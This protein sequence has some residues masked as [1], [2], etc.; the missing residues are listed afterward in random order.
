MQHIRLFE[1]RELRIE[2]S[3]YHGKRYID[4][5]QWFYDPRTDKWYA[6]RKGLTIEVGIARTLIAAM[7]EE[8]REKKPRSKPKPPEPVPEPTLEDV[9]GT[10]DPAA[11]LFEDDDTTAPF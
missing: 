9:A 3:T 10:V 7:A 2:L 11:E 8:L 1:D 6:S 4:A 5:R